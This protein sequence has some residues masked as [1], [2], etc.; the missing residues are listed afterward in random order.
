M[1]KNVFTTEEVKTL[2][3]N[4]YVASVSKRALI[5]TPEFK[6]RAYDELIRGKSIRQVFEDAGLDPSI[7]GE[8]RM[9]GYRERILREAEREEGFQNLRKNNHRREAQSTQ[10]QMAKRIRQLE[11]QVVYLQQE[12]EFIKK[13][14]QL[15][16]GFDGKAGKRN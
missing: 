5:L 10:A 15:E 4:P 8:T 7:V 11:H 16:K 3:E 1:S 2:A 6:Q 12:N 14:Q 13:I 9:H